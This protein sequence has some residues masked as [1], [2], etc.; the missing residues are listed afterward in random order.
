MLLPSQSLPHRVPP[1]SLLPFSCMRTQLKCFWWANHTLLL[2]LDLYNAL[3]SSAPP[4]L[5]RQPGDI[6]SVRFVFLVKEVSGSVQTELN[7]LM[8]SR[9]KYIFHDKNQPPYPTP[10]PTPQPS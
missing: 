4:I 5:G 9:M 7:K 8:S 2:L 3:A 6:F 10:T 1:P